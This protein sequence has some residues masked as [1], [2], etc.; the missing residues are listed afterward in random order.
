M[1]EDEDFPS[2][3]FGRESGKGE[4]HGASLLQE[5]RA[6]LSATPNDAEPEAGTI[7]PQAVGHFATEELVVP[8][9]SGSAWRTVG[10]APTSRR[11]CRRKSGLSQPFMLAPNPCGFVFFT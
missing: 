6:H 9:T 11:V 5:I 2:G 4:L 7:R 10:K 3:T 8:R 1:Q